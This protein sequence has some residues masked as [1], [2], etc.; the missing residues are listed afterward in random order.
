[1]GGFHFKKKYSF[2]QKISSNTAIFKKKYF[3]NLIF[4]SYTINLI[5][6]I[7]DFLNEKKK[8]FSQFSPYL[9]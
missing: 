7:Y 6:K 9:N 4:L 3:E 2:K 5:F 8:I 1:M